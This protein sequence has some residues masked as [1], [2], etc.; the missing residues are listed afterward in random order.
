VPTV[1][2]PHENE[3]AEPLWNDTHRGQLLIPPPELSGNPTS[4][5]LVASRRNE[6]RKLLIWPYE[7][8]LFILPQVIFLHAVKS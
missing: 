8:F 6:P 4:S 1:H 5:H 7:V 3:H 2:P